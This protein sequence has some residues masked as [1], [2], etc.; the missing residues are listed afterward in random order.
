MNNHT[1]NNVIPACSV[2]KLLTLNNKYLTKSDLISDIYN[3][4]YI[5]H[6]KQL[7]VINAFLLNWKPQ[8]YLTMI[9]IDTDGSELIKHMGVYYDIKY[10]NPLNFNTEIMKANKIALSFRQCK[11]LNINVVVVKIIKPI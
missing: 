9:H 10:I 2:K 6:L 7:G 4:W 3:E 11:E 1:T 8:Y 5:N